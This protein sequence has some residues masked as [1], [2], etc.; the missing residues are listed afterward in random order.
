MGTKRMTLVAAVLGM[1]AAAGMMGCNQGKAK[2]KGAASVS[3]NALSISDVVSMTVS[4]QGGGMGSPLVVP[5]AKKGNQF[6]ALV[7]DLPVGTDYAFTASAKD[8]STPAV[9]LYHGGVT[10]QT[11]VKNQTA[12]IVINMNQVAPGVPM[13][14]SAPVIDSLTASSLKVSNGDTVTISATAR[15]PDAGETAGIGWSWTSSCAGTL[16]GVQTVA[17]TDAKDG[18]STVTFTAPAT[19]GP[20]Q[21]NL[22]VTDV[23]GSLTNGASLTIQVNAS[24]GTGNA[25]ITALPN[26]FPVISDLQATPVPLVKGT[27]TKLTVLATDSDGD[28]LN[29]KLEHGQL[30]VRQLRHDHRCQREF[31]P[32]CRLVGHH[33]HLQ[34]GG[35]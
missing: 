34:R 1:V 13:S 9:E 29:Y 14:N 11:I 22:T 12:N 2:D 5:L 18:T 16:S 4:V 19:D 23:H 25:K 27:A 32:G 6:S 21:V 20:C 15:D 3:V 10:L 8:G 28:T 26:T 30:R 35:G 33:L 24:T 7:S 31:H 17:G